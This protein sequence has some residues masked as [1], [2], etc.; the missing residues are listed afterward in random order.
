MNRWDRH[1]QNPPYYAV[2]FS[3]EPGPELEGYAEMDAET[4]ELAQTM[5]GYLAHESRNDGTGT[6]FISYWKDL[7]SIDHWSRNERHRLA[8]KGGRS[9]WY[10]WYHSQ[11]CRVERGNF[12]EFENEEK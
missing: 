12:F 6:N 3:Y 10:G 2:I 9:G 7:D 8:K 1:K 11:T 5:P 4:I